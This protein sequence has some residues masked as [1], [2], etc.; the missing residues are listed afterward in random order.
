MVVWNKQ[1]I[2]KIQNKHKIIE[3]D[4][5]ICGPAVHCSSEADIIQHVKIEKNL[6]KA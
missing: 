6:F 5:L 2:S 4:A 1:N 3:S